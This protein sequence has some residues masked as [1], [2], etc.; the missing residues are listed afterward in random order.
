MYRIQTYNN[1]AIRGLDRFPRDRYEVASD[2]NQPDALM[3]RSFNLHDVD[4]PESVLAVG[5]AG[6]G[7]NNIPVTA[8]SDRG[9]AVFNAPG[10]NA[11]AVK[12]LVIAGLLL[13]ARNL[14]PAAGYVQ[15][16]D[17]SKDD[18]MAAVEHGKKRFT[19]F[20][21]PGR[22]LAVLGLGAIGVGVANAAK[23]L[24][25]EVVGF[26]P[27]VTVE[28]AWR[29]DSDIERARSVEAALEG[30][31][32][33]TVH[34]PLTENTR[35]IVNAKGLA[36]MNP[37]A[38]VLNLA[39][40]GIVDDEAVREGLDAERLHAYITDFPV[41]NMLG[42]PRVITLPHLG[43]STTESEE[44]CAV[45]IADEL[46]DYLENGNVVNSVNLPTLVLDRKGDTR[47]AVVNRNLP[48]RVARIS[49][50]LGESNLNILHLMNDSRGDLAY[51]LL[52][53]DGKPDPSTLDALLQI[54]G[55]LRA[56]VL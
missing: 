47:I 7:V 24:G 31:D 45:M 28:N 29:L 1:I 2:I 8:L 32:A 22:K 49:H 21:L 52:D 11:N 4:I 12:E 33:V 38:M 20:E 26:D 54:D 10:A 14:L 40:E 56:R 53:V 41:P 46:R 50:V 34:V 19:G 44:N 37:G 48:D 27:K 30:A 39:R 36:G 16:L 6:S 43:A 3:L 23:A 25:M 9:V 18:F 51:T 55:V 17:P 5:R 13:G 42:H 15:E 35:H